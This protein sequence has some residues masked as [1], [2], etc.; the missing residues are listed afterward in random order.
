MTMLVVVVALFSMAARVLNDGEKFLRIQEGMTKAEVE[1]LVGRPHHVRNDGAWFYDL[2]DVGGDVAV[3]FDDSER[4][5]FV[6]DIWP[7]YD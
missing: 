7:E 6:D 1:A 5:F 4:V 3:R 2:W